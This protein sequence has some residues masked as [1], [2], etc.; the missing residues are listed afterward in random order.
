MDTEVDEARA[1]LEETVIMTVDE[2][3]ASRRLG[4]T[5][6]WQHGLVD[7]CH[8]PHPPLT[9]AELAATRGG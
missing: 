5:G 4:P 1:P 8:R 6:H 7:K 9:A 3:E 2:G